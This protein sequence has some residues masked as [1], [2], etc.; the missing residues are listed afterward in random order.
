MTTGHP[1]LADKSKP[2]YGYELAYRF[3]GEQ[4]AK[5]E[6]IAGQC[7]RSGARCEEAGSGKVITLEYINQPYRI[8]LPDIEIT[9]VGSAE[10]VKVKDRILILQYF[11]LAKGKPPTHQL[12]TYKEIPDGLNYFPTFSKRAIRPII[13]YFGDQPERLLE[14]GQKLGGRKADYGDVAVT[15]DGFS[16]VPIT[17]VLWRGDEE[18]P[19]QASILFDSTISDYLTTEDIHV[20]CET[21]AWKLVRLLKSG[22]ENTGKK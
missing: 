1:P 4:L 21:I 6:D 22:G 12:I 8:T 14:M 10:P 19:P 2:E 16:R 17:F 15:I 7:R 9:A 13:S 3:A 18:F 20:L 11:I 5:I